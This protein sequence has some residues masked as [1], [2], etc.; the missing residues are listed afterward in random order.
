MPDEMLIATDLNTLMA[1][2]RSLGPPSQ[3]ASDP[4]A[5]T[6]EVGGEAFWLG[7]AS[8]R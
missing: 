5:Q 3:A 2:N 7:P 4:M 1:L 8:G 6:A